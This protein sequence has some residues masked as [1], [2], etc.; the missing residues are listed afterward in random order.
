MVRKERSK[1]GAEGRGETKVKK[2][3]D[4]AI[5]INVIEE[6]LNV[7]KNN[8]CCKAGPDSSLSIVN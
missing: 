3:M 2:Y 4:D 7:K 5:N 6:A 8:R 1:P